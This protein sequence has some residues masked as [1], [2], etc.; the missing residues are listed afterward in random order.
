[1]ETKQINIAIHYDGIHY[2]GWAIPSDR[3]KDDGKPASF[4]V[5]LNDTL[6]GNVSHNGTS[7]V[8][9]EQRPQPLTDKVGDYLKEHL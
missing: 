8:V 5:V 3:K 9:D 2:T 1:M 4:H 7:W 6:F